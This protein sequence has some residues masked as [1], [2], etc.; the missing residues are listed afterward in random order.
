MKYKF[1]PQG[2]ATYICKKMRRVK[3]HGSQE[4]RVKNIFP[5][6]AKCI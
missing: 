1:I 5:R 2:M 3:N 6:E 4:S